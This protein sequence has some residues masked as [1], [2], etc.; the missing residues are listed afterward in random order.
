MRM[1][2]L[3]TK[4]TNNTKSFVSYSKKKPSIP[5]TK[6]KSIPINF[7][8]KL[9]AKSGIDLS[10][11]K[12]HYNSLKPRKIGASAYTQ[13]K[14]I[15]I[16]PNQEKHIPHESWHCVQQIQGRVKPTFKYGNNLVNND[17]R[18][19]KEAD[20]VSQE[21]CSYNVDSQRN[22]ARIKPNF[23]TRKQVIQR[24]EIDDKESKSNSLKHL[25]SGIVRD[26]IGDQGF[27]KHLK[28]I[29]LEL[30]ALAIGG[31]IHGGPNRLSALGIGNAFNQSAAA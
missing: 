28:I 27:K 31:S 19:E 9:E 16:A 18:L 21:L 1:N 15:Y 7:K 14:N 3:A 5:T 25:I 23:N 29:A 17:I 24:R 22:T 6:P 12:I 30:Q 10:E 26:N 13:G 8:S 4:D 20:S 2:R 11:V